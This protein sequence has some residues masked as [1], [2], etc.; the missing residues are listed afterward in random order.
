MEDKLAI[1]EVVQKWVVWRD[2]GDWERF[3]TVC[4]RTGG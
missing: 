4:I 1:T 3:R 2:T